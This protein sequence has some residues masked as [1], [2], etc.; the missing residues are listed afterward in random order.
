MN[1]EIK[2]D[3]NA[4]EQ[5]IDYFNNILEQQ[6]FLSNVIQNN[7]NAQIQKT[8]N[9]IHSMTPIVDQ[10]YQNIHNLDSQIRTIISNNKN[11]LKDD[12]QFQNFLKTDLCTDFTK[13]INEID[14]LVFNLKKLLKKE[15]IKL[16]PKIE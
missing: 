13:K 4:I 10:H 14:T 16:L 15:G 6:K 1:N 8:T 9:I 3:Q 2:Y 12:I 11:N 7:S 5:H